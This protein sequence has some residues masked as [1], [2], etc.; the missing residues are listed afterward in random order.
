MFIFVNMNS[1]M[2]VCMCCRHTYYF[3]KCIVHEQK[4]LRKGR[5]GTQKDGARKE[6]R[7]KFRSICTL[8]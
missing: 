6:D 3:N 5:V 7:R 4:G 1:C 8:R 2:L